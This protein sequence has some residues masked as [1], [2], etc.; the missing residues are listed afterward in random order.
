MVS[1]WP[2]LTVSGFMISGFGIF[3]ILITGVLG[4]VIFLAGPLMIV[5]GIILKEPNPPKPDAPNKRY[6]KFCMAEVDAESPT[7]SECGFAE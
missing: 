6:C 2:A 5:A 3:L 7:C 4:L 1:M